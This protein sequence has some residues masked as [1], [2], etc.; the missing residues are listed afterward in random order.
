MAKQKNEIVKKSNS[1]IRAHWP[2]ESV[3]EPRIVAFLASKIH[4]SDEDF[5]T[6]TI[7]LSEILGKNYGGHDIDELEAAAKNIIKHPVIIQ[8]TPK[9]RAIYPILSK[10]VIDS[11]TGYI[12][13][14]FDADLKPHFLQLKEHFTQYSLVE[15]LNLS[16]IYSQRLYEILKSYRGQN[17]VELTLDELYKALNFPVALRSNF[18]HFRKKVLEQADKEIVR[19]NLS[20]QYRWDVIKSGRGGKVSAIRFTFRPQKQD[21]ENDEELIRARLS[22]LSSSCYFGLLKRKVECTPKPNKSAKCKY[23]IENGN[24]SF[25]L[26][27]KAKRKV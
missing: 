19:G 20:I 9:R 3:W 7:P 6:Y 10:C 15:F 24:M 17:Y 4:V 12:E 23:C 16:S 8:Q 22:K 18:A 1:I 26:K 11:G 5:K 13:L 14:R 27:S 21:E 2:V 25:K